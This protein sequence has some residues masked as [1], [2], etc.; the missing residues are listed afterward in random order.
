M[1]KDRA[2]VHRH[3]ILFIALISGGIFVMA[4]KSFGAP[5]RLARVVSKDQ[6]FFAGLNIRRAV[7]HRLRRSPP[8]G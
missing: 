3:F 4:L 2:I 8:E 5:A 7:F 1:A 6:A